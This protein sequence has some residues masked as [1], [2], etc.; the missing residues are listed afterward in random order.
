[1][2]WVVVIAI[3][4]FM[5]WR[6]TGLELGDLKPLPKSYAEKPRPKI[7][8]LKPRTAPPTP[9]ETA[10]ALT[11]MRVVHARIEDV[12]NKEYSGLSL[13]ALDQAALSLAQARALDPSAVLTVETKDG[14]L[15]Y[16]QDQMALRILVSEG[17]AHASF[18]A[19]YCNNYDL[20]RKKEIPRAQRDAFAAMQKALK[21]N[22]DNPGT[23]IAFADVLWRTDQRKDAKHIMDGAL[24]KFPDNVDVIMKHQDMSA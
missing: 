15:E 24:K 11:M 20:Y 22:P 23:Y 21:Y 4:L 12:N 10:K 17:Y 16:T 6:W 18:Y 8:A 7:P 5:F 3:L 13:Q 9:Q 19:S 1:M 2:E 14:R